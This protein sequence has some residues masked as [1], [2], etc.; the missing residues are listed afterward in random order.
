M[1]YNSVWEFRQLLAYRRI[2]AH[3]DIVDLD[4]D[5]TTLRIGRS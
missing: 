3:Y 2:P 5:V 4:E 1:L